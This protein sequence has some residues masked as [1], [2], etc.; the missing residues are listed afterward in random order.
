MKRRTEA[1]IATCE[2]KYLMIQ[3]GPSRAALPASL[4]RVLHSRRDPSPLLDDP[5]GDRL[6]P[7]SERDKFCQRILARMDSEARVAALRAPGS[8]L[9]DFRRTNTASPAAVFRSRSRGDAL[10][11]AMNR[12]FGN[13]S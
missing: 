1:Y 5:W 13:M 11:A 6:V 12:G 10:R 2:G 7:N 8:I 4:M 9:D 3:P